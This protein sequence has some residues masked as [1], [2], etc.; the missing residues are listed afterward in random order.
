[1]TI[2]KTISMEPTTLVDRINL[3]KNDVFKDRVLMT[4][5]QWCHTVMNHPTTDDNIKLKSKAVEILNQPEAFR[6]RLAYSV[7]AIVP[8]YEVNPPVWE[9]LWSKV[10]DALDAIAGQGV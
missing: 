8:D 7:A 6:D 5:V 2:T 4:A 1:M 9:T 10:A 3:S